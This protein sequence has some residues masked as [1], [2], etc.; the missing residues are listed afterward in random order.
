MGFR[1]IFGPILR[2][3][4]LSMDSIT[5]GIAISGE[6]RGKTDHAKG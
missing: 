2:P 1:E 4:N 6:Q 5:A 3:E